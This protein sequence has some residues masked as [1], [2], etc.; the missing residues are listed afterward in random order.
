DESH[1][2]VLTLRRKRPE[3]LPRVAATGTRAPWDELATLVETEARVPIQFRWVGAWLNAGRSHVDLVFAATT[4]ESFDLPGRAEWSL[5]RQVA[6]PAREAANVSRIRPSF[7]R[8][9]V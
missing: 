9:A 8:D 6:L 1:R 4:L 2:R 3:S 7:A 5:A